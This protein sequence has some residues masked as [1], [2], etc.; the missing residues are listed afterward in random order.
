[1][2]LLPA[3]LVLT[4]AAA[5][6]SAQ[7]ARSAPLP[8]MRVLVPAYFY[9]VPGSPWDRLDL[10]AE[11]HPALVWAIGNPASGPGAS[12]DPT[13]VA[14]FADFRRRGGRLLGYVTS[15]YGAK[16]VAT[17]A[18]EADL[19]VQWYGVDGIFIDEMDNA[20]GAH[21]SYYAT[22]YSTLTLAHPSAKI[23]AN[24]GVATTLDYLDGAVGRCADTL[25][26][27]ENSTPFLSWNAD[28]WV[29]TRP[30]REFYALPYATSAADWPAYVTHAFQQNVGWFYTTDDV[31]PNP[32][33]T[34]PVWFETMV[35][36][37]DASY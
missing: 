4:L 32:W 33:D 19:W 26:I 8:R 24:P 7:R 9:P 21:E 16:P 30:R 36:T 13:Y 2:R 6:T 3:L 10:V 15:S 18:A 22:V 20:P 34:L 11:R 37:I 27:H 25:C 29:A 14:T 1:M 17:L 5:S 35:D 28:P 31:L 12:P 23:V